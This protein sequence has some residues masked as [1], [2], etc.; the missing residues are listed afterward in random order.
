MNSSLPR[1]LFGLAASLVA[2]DAAWAVL[3][4]FSIDIAGYARLGLL[5][6]ALLG[7]GFFYS[8]RRPEPNLAAMLM[9]ASFLCAFSAAA[10]LL[11]Y[12]LL[13][14]AGPRI[15]LLLAGID[16]AMGFDWVQLMVAMSHHP[17]LNAVFFY[18][19]GSTLPQIALLVVVLAWSGRH[20]EIYRFCLAIA[21][22]ALITIFV[23]AAAPSLG[24]ESVYA[25][26]PSVAHDLVVAVGG[27]YGRA[28]AGLLHNGPGFIT[29]S[30][31][32]GLIGFPSYHTVMALLIA[33][34]AR[35]VAWLRWPALILNLAVV[36]SAPV[37]GGHHLMDIFGGAV[38]TL[39]AVLA[40]WGAEKIR[41]PS[42]AAVASRMP[43]F[44]LSRSR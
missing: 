20:Q 23:W 39:L 18:V 21:A 19:Y 30:D 15:D 2:V 6:L 34:Y 24:A 9:G 33:W 17:R 37:Q 26:P 25:L 8:A 1:I 12:F 4:H 3:G 16:R 43:K 38:V 11:N 14:V 35:G 13:T 28:L 7:G 10:S 41:L 32:R 40:V 44:A 36:A 29:P 31:I 5:S 22:G 42:F 27:D